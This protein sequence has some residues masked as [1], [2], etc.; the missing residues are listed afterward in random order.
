M[1]LEKKML[2]VVYGRLN[3]SVRLGRLKCFFEKSHQRSAGG[4]RTGV[5]V[6]FCL[7]AWV[8]QPERLQLEVEHF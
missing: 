6:P 4:K 1:L 2:L 5:S 7:S 3:A 8:S